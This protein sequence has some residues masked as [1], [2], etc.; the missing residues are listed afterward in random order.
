MY[1]PANT[2]DAAMPKD[3]SGSLLRGL[4]T[5]LASPGAGG[6]AALPLGRVLDVIFESVAQPVGESMS[7][8]AFVEGADGCDRFNVAW[9][10]FLP[11]AWET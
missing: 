3:Q 10:I 2:S 7:A 11:L 4:G 5:A 1:A 6:C 9:V 8:I